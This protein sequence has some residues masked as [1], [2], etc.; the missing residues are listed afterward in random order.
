MTPCYSPKYLL[1]VRHGAEVKS[2]AY[3]PLSHEKQREYTIVYPRSQ[4]TMIF[5][6]C[7]F[8]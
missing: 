1:D 8:E 4:L 3:L 5:H 6:Y 7:L 2:E